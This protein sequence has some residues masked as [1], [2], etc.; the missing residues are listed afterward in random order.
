MEFHTIPLSPKSSLAPDGRTDSVQRLSSSAVGS[1]ASTR[2]LSSHSHSHTRTHHSLIP[3]P[4]ST[5]LQA[6]IQT[7]LRLYFASVICDKERERDRELDLR[8]TRIVWGDRGDTTSRGSTG[9]HSHPSN[10]SRTVETQDTL[11]FAG[12]AED[13]VILSWPVTAVA[14]VST[15][16]CLG[17]DLL[18]SNHTNTRRGFPK[19]AQA[20]NKAPVLPPSHESLSLTPP[21]ST[22]KSYLEDSGYLSQSHSQIILPSHISQETLIT[23]VYLQYESNT[24]LQAT[25][26]LSSSSRHHIFAKMDFSR[27]EG[28]TSQPLGEESLSYQEE[29][30]TYDSTTDFEIADETPYH[31]EGW[32][33]SVEPEEEA[34]GKPI[35][36]EHL[37]SIVE[38]ARAEWDDSEGLWEDESDGEGEV[39]GDL[40]PTQLVDEAGDPASEKEAAVDTREGDTQEKDPADLTLATTSVRALALSTISQNDEDLGEVDL[41]EILSPEEIEFVQKRGEERAAEA[42]AGQNEGSAHPESRLH[43]AET[44]ASMAQSDSTSPYNSE[45]ITRLSA[46]PE[47]P[48]TRFM[49]V[50]NMFDRDKARKV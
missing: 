15:A 29:Y 10:S 36:P 45:E 27:S 1:G 43:E 38:R 25:A 28:G 11:L 41:S 13:S 37:T 6:Q 40:A 44:Q 22:C 39:P 7:P 14:G 12:S 50:W 34:L 8:F 33:E 4:I 47:K 19:K 20:S 9:S 16:R 46:L 21:G 42:E 30:E 17:L 26:G 31:N 49:H 3:T 35:L 23:P 24:N 5:P 32:G 2:V 48:D 18:P